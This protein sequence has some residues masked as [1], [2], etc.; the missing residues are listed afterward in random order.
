[1]AGPQARGYTKDPWSRGPFLRVLRLFAANN[2]KLLSM[3]NLQLIANFR[4]QGQSR[5]IKANRVIPM[6]RKPAKNP[7]E[8]WSA[9]VLGFSHHSTTPPPQAQLRLN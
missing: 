1:M 9:G 8:C 7:T 5:L 3:N 2:P 6:F 4:N